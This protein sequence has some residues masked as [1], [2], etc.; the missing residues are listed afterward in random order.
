MSEFLI[1][2]KH[3]GQGKDFKGQGDSIGIPHPK[4]QRMTENDK[5]KGMCI[6]Q[7][8]CINIKPT[9]EWNQKDY[10][11]ERH[12]KQLSPMKYDAKTLAREIETGS[13]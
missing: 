1:S 10:A 9:E 11:I 5:A 8:L 13:G 7:N 3:Q 4:Q 12:H 6:T 2:W